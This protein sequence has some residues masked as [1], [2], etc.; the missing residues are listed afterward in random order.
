MTACA[1]LLSAGKV[2]QQRLKMPQA[3][4]SQ[5]TELTVTVLL[6]KKKIPLTNSCMFDVADVQAV[7]APAE[8]RN[9]VMHHNA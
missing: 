4:T 3:A 2:E 9:D 7:S 6:G 8:K 5:V 1:F